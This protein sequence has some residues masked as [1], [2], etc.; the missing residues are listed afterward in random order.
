[1]VINVALS[2]AIDL[3][4]ISLLKETRDVVLA[5]SNSIVFLILALE[6]IQGAIPSVTAR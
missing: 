3:W 2:V 4:Q 1:M 6:N 5:Q